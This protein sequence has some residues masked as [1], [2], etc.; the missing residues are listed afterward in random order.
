MDGGG[1]LLQSV[2][3][4][5]GAASVRLPAARQNLTTRNTAVAPAY[6]FPTPVVFS[7]P[8]GN[9]LITTVETLA[10]STHKRAGLIFSLALIAAVGVFGALRG[11]QY[12]A[13]VAAN[14]TISDIIARA[15]GFG[16]AAVTISSQGILPEA[17]V[18]K[19]GGITPNSSLVFINA[20][21]LRENLL[22][23]PA[24]AD[25]QVRK[26]YPDRLTIEI[27]ERPAYALWQ[28]DGEV[29]VISDAGAVIG[30]LTDLR[31]AGLPFV[32]G[33]GAN[34][35]AQDFTKLMEAAGDQHTKFRAG[36]FVGQRRWDLITTNGVTVKLPEHNPDAALKVLAELER[37]NRILEKDVIALDMRMKD[38]VVARL[39]E[40]GASSRG[41]QLQK[42]NP[43]SDI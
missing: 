13:F 2:N 7:A 41:E 24:V 1:R 28:K 34:L 9:A 23:L 38:R 15:L 27:T 20:A 26:L 4:L 32:V 36:I 14:G 33:D 12:E 6:T 16:V 11:G 29:R 3:T 25:A 35:H 42:K 37:Q 17:E 18:L 40:G 22:A 30:P 19:A 39:T 10:A 43:G 8:Q 21:Q 31:L 5:S